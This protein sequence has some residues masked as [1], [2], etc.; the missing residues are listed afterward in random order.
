MNSQVS[1]ERL[2]KNYVFDPEEI[3]RKLAI[4]N[5]LLQNSKDES[6]REEFE[7]RELMYQNESINWKDTTI[8]CPLA[9]K[10]LL[11]GFS[12]KVMIFMSKKLPILVTG[13]P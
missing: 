3:E 4:I 2:N 5:G 12:D 11:R 1:L 7:G 6:P 13:I 8:F 9:P 10:K